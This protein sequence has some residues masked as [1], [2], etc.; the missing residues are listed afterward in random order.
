MTRTVVHVSDSCEFGGTEQVILQLIGGLDRTKWTPVLVHQDHVSA[1]ALRDAARALDVRSVAVR[2]RSGRHGVAQIPELVSLLR[3]LAPR[4]VHAHL[5]EPLSCRFLLLAA[6]WAGV[7]AVVATLQLFMQPRT[8]RLPGLQHRVVATAVDRYIAVSHH[9]GS[10]LR[11][12]LGVSAS[13]IRVIHNA[14]A[15]EQFG[16]AR[17]RPVIRTGNSPIVLTVARLDPQKGHTHL[18]EAAAM[19]PGVVFLLAGTGSERAAL[20]AQARRS[21]ISDRVQFLEHRVDVPDLLRAA[22]VFVLPSLYEGLPLSVLEAMASAKPVVATAV[23][24]TNEAVVDGVT[25]ILV[26]PANPAALG[27]AI[28]GILDDPETAARLGAAGRERVVSAFSTRQMIRATEQVYEELF[29]EQQ[30]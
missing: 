9:V 5:T 10:Q 22:D 19:L 4:V 20:E 15:V 3:R 16:D 12:R 28:R 21:G 2:F 26:P 24:G 30:S 14:I 25:G 29:P 13:R 1:Q 6:A 18:L 17:D 11:H 7:P 23:G 27:A 8:A